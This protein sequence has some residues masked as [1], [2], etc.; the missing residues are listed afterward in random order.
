MIL[1][2]SNIFSQWV[3][4][5]VRLKI[6]TQKLTQNHLRI[7][8]IILFVIINIIWGTTFPL[9]EKTVGSL[10]PSV[11]IATRFCVA[12][13]LFSGN[14]RGLNKLILRDGLLLGLVFFAYLAIETIALES[15]HANR[16]AFIVSLSAILV[17]LLGSF[18]GRR[19]PGKTFFS[20]GLAV[21][22]I[23]VMFWG[24]GVLG[25]GDLLMLGDAVLYAVYTLI[26]EQIAPRHPSL[27]LTSIQLFVIAI[28]GALWSNTSL[29]DEM[30]II[31]ENW[32]VIFYLGLVATAIVIWL[33]TVAQQ[34]IR[35]EEA[36][37]LYTLEPI[38]S[39][40][41]SFLILGE[42]L[43]LSGFIGATFVLSAIVFSQKPQDL[44]LDT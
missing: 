14:L 9:I 26:L 38:F 34:W 24:G 27:S 1:F 17:P 25:I 31:N 42:Q 16:A 5:A 36:A 37:L 8:G 7:Q 39:A 4:A 23:G 35:S 40:I 15:I 32:G 6:F 22:G 41:F 33:Q 2:F 11:L 29:I 20:A 28:L 10:S 18:F 12:A 13:L 30:N 21:I 3:T 44:Q 43:G 19:L